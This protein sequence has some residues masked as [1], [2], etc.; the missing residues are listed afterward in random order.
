M[1]RGMARS[2]RPL[3]QQGRS[4]IVTREAGRKAK[5]L[6]LVVAVGLALGVGLSQPLGLWVVG[7]LV[8]A[9]VSAVGY[10]VAPEAAV[11][12][13]VVLRPVVDVYIYRFSFSGLY[14]GLLWEGLMVAF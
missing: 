13:L 12:S 3:A 1:L 10:A 11:L 4:W 14:L 9:T 8:L 6:A 5:P 7:A 2:L